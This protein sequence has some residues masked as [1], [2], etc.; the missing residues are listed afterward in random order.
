MI[1]SFCF[2]AYS[3][4][5]CVKVFLV[6]MKLIRYPLHKTHLRFHSLSLSFDNWEFMYWV[7]L[8]ILLCASYLYLPFLVRSKNVQT[9]NQ[10]NCG[11]TNHLMLFSGRGLLNIASIL[12]R[13]S[14]YTEFDDVIMRLEHSVNLI[15]YVENYRTACWKLNIAGE[16]LTDIGI[17]W[18]VETSSS[19][20]ACRFDRWRWFATPI[21]GGP[22]SCTL[23]FRNSRQSW[24]TFYLP[25][26]RPSLI[27]TKSKIVYV[28]L[29]VINRQ[30]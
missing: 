22:T 30:I 12:K 17:T 5:N 11:C 23:N 1:R 13:S 15:F 4:G 2:F 24:L 20:H 16:G 27:G 29:I 21:R 28:T 14:L 7:A 9:R 25:D 8:S 6:I 10:T 3:L 26:F 19:V 18:F